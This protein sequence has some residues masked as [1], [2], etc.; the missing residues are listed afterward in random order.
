MVS[1]GLAGQA[2]EEERGHSLPHTRGVAP[3][4]NRQKAAHAGSRCVSTAQHVVAWH[5]V[6]ALLRVLGSLRFHAETDGGVGRQGVKDPFPWHM[7]RCRLPACRCDRL[8]TD[9]RGV[10]PRQEMFDSLSVQSARRR[11]KML[12]GLSIRTIRASPMGPPT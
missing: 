7:T 6:A 2:E 4:E 1:P 5:T 12:G 3:A 9:G 8:S 10:F 11:H